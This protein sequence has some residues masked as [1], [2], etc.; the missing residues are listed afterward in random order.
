[1]KERI[2]RAVAVAESLGA[3]VA[4][5]VEPNGHSALIR[6]HVNNRCAFGP[7]APELAEAFLCGVGF[8]L[9]SPIGSA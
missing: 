5:G 2:D 3:R 7:A 4:L 6:V 9:Q 1:M 8:A